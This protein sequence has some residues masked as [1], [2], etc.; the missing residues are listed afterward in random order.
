MRVVNPDGSNVA[1]GQ[2]QGASL[3]TISINS[4]QWVG[5]QSLPTLSIGVMPALSFGALATGSNP[6]GFVSIPSITGNVGIL[7]NVAIVGTATVNLGSSLPAGTNSLGFVSLPSINGTVSI[8]GGVTMTGTATVNLGSSLPAGTNSLGFVSLPSINGT[9]V[10]ATGTN[11]IGFV[12]L[13]SITG[14]VGI[15]GSVA[16]TGTATVNLGSALPTGT[17]SVGFVSLPS[18]TGVVGLAGGSNSIGFVSLP[19]ITGLVDLNSDG[20]PGSAVPSQGI[21]IAGNDGTNLRGFLTTSAA[22]LTGASTQA[23]LLTSAFDEWSISHR[24]AAATKATISKGAGAAGVR[25]VATAFSFTIAAGAT[26]QTPLQIDIIDGASGGATRLWSGTIACPANGMGVVAMSG[27]AFYGTA[28]T[29]LT[30][31][32]SAAG[33]ANTV[34]AVTLWGYSTS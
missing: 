18:I 33:A 32:F 23:V 1:A 10:N 11:S 30:L 14:Q 5:A 7:G 19:S 9:V 22:N 20:A 28:A 26:A 31:E 24:P 21:Y 12:S 3:A 13:P 25:H 4:G 27:V 6:I 15:T 17:N 29:A 2:G 8:S 34:Q 16:M